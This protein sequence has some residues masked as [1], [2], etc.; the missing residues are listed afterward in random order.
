MADVFN[1]QLSLPQEWTISRGAIAYK[2]IGLRDLLTI[3]CL[4]TLATSVAGGW[5]LNSSMFC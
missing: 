3:L 1:G 4:G 2:T 5:L